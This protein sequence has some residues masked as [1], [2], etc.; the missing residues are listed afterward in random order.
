V[1]TV[2]GAEVGTVLKVDGGG[3]ATRLVV[4][5]QKEEVLVPLVDEICRQIDPA[6]KRIVIAAPDGLLGLNEVSGRRREWRGRRR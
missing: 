2:D 4:A 1:E 6:A 3:A 5:G